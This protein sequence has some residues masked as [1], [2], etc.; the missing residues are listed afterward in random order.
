M[1]LEWALL[2]LTLAQ[3]IVLVLLQWRTRQLRAR[4]D[5]LAGAA[6]TDVPTSMLVAA[7]GRMEQRLLA[8][9]GRLRETRLHASALASPI[10]R[11]PSPQ[12]HGYELARHLAQ[13][14]AA[15]ELLVERCGLSRD[16]AELIRHLHAG[17][18][19]EV[20]LNRL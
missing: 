10:E 16:E 11:A 9:E 20:A 4:L 2:A 15:V 6:T 19:H 14:G 5:V 8:I 12:P 1:G 13:Q 3:G 7:L 18:G 17:V